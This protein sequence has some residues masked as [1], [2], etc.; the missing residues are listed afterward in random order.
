MTRHGAGPAVRSF[1]SIVSRSVAVCLFLSAG[2]EPPPLTENG[3]VG[4][5]G[6]EGLGK[7]EFHYPRAI[8]SESD[9]SVFVVDKTGR[10]QRFS[11]KG[12]LETD[13]RMPRI[14]SGKP[15]GM[16]MHTD[17]RLF[18][19]D[20]HYNRVLITDRDGKTIGSFGKPGMGEGEFQLP[21]DVTVDAEGFIYVSEYHLTE[22]VSKWTSDF[23]FVKFIGDGEI[24][25]ARLSR[26]AAIEIDGEQTL[27]VADACN[28][29]LIRFSLDGEVL[30]IVGGFGTEPGKLKYPYDLDITPEGNL[31]VCEYG[32]NRLQWLSKDGRSLGVWGSAGRKPGELFAPWGATYGPEGKIFVVDARNN[33]IQ[34]IGPDAAP[35]MTGR[36]VAR[37]DGR[38]ND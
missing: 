29:R 35:A 5:I 37:A 7:G 26:P 21:T 4:I 2:C 6:R 33:R 11:G 3:V 28:H 18:I 38:N 10:I 32:G 15:V 23:T 31:L 19:A 1:A 36:Q 24:E 14:D 30:A 34:I 9:G 25:G 13:W 27:W 17:G 16:Y 22:R 8:T 12:E 20:T